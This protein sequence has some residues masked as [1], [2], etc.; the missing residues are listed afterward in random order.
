MERRRFFSSA[1]ASLFFSVSHLLSSSI[2]R[3][4]RSSSASV[5]TASFF[6][7][8][9]C[10]LWMRCANNSV[11]VDSTTALTSGLSVQITGICVPPESEGCS[12]RVSLEPE[13][14]VVASPNV[15]TTL[16]RVGYDNFTYFFPLDA[17][18]ASVTIM[19]PRVS[20]LKTIRSISNQYGRARSR[21]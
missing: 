3:R 21:E 18:S 12:M 19:L 9:S 16:S 5:S 6:F 17:F 11:L 1:S 7:A 2:S 4:Y 8:F 14:D 20:K 13:Y 15:S 10:T